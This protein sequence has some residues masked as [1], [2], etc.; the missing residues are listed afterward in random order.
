MSDT[1]TLV[2]SSVFWISGELDKKLWDE[3]IGC[4]ITEDCLSAHSFSS[5][6]VCTT[7]WLWLSPVIGS[8]NSAILDHEVGKSLVD[9]V[10]DFWIRSG[11][12][13]ET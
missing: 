9:L 1:S 8:I 10:G 7:V 2:S 5:G 4:E 6:R 13:G 11:K 3:T 12:E